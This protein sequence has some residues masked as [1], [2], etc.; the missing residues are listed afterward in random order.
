MYD[1]QD[2]HLRHDHTKNDD[3]AADRNRP[4]VGSEFRSRLGTLGKA[5]QEADPAEN[6]R[7]KSLGRARIFCRNPRVDPIEIAPR[8]LTEDDFR[9]VSVG[10]YRPWQRVFA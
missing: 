7:T 2:S 1:P 4:N 5:L 3:I 8:S 6:I 9:H 10:A